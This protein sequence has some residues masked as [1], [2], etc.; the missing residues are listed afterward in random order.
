M[1][2]YYWIKLYHEVLDDPKMGRLSDHLWRRVIELFLL[3]GE[4]NQKG[5][6]PPISD[7]AWKLRT[8]DEELLADLKA[9]EEIGIVA[10]TEARWLVV[11]FAERQAPVCDAERKQRQR[12]RD[13]LKDDCVTDE[14]Q[15]GHAAVTECDTDIDTDIDIDA[16]PEQSPPAASFQDWHRRIETSGN[17]PAALREMFEALYPGRSPPGFGYLGKVARAV[18]GAGRLAE[19]LWEHSTKP[20]TGDVLAYVQA[21][22]KRAKRKDDKSSADEWLAK[23]QQAGMG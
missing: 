4:T 22:A 14:T 13:R 20:P 5:L 12:I 2:S 18:G 7:V 1:K 15:D 23:R 11:K 8:N 10:Q 21:V 17:R 9:L 6:L 3:A 19:L 16:D